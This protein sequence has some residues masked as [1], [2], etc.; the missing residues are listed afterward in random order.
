MVE[1]P[2]LRTETSDEDERI[3]ARRFI[4]DRNEELTSDHDILD[5]C[6][7]IYKD[8][9]KGFMDQWERSNNTLDYWD[10]YNCNLGSKQFYSGNSKIFAPIVHDAINARKTRFVNQIFPASG[11]H[12]E[13]TGSED[14][15][16]GLTS[17]LEFYIRKAKLR[18]RVMPGLVRNGDIEGQYKIMMHRVENHRH[19]AMRTKKSP[20]IDGMP[21]EGADEIED[22]GQEEIIHAY[23]RVEGVE[24]ERRLCRVRF[25]SDEIVLSV[26]RNPYWCDKCPILSAAVEQVEGSFKG[27]PKIKFVESMQYQ[28]ND[29]INE[30][31]DSAAYALLPIIMTDPARNP[32]TGSMVLNVA[33]VWEVDSQSARVAQ[34]SRVGE[35]GI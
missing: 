11:K 32:R 2:D 16:Q 4:D 15:P 24:E 1:K 26:K 6:I 27:A 35:E 19:V 33:A 23:P 34:F 7:D 13:V 14:R 9:E 5:A 10:I 29:A 17:L 25:G 3:T 12:V 30:G 31:M 20:K 8:I 22:S 18:T 21:I 28:A